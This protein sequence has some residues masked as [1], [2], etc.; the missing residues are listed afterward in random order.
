MP[1]RNGNCA[2]GGVFSL[3]NGARA[4]EQIYTSTYIA[5]P[6]NESNVC[7]VKMFLRVNKNEDK[8]WKGDDGTFLEPLPPHSGSQTARLSE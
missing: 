5:D 3:I 6:A 1:K 4:L 2:S 8:R 7:M